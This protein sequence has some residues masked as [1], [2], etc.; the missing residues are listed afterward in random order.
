[1]DTKQPAVKAARAEREAELA[2]ALRRSQ[3][4]AAR[5]GLEEDGRRA[6]A[7]DETDPGR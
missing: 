2:A 5:E 3:I 6:P 4:K 1:M 7:K